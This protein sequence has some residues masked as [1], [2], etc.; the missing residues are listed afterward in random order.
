MAEETEKP[1]RPCCFSG[2]A[3]SRDSNSAVRPWSLPAPWI[4]NPLLGLQSQISDIL[5]LVVARSLKQPLTL[6]SRSQTRNREHRG[7]GDNCEHSSHRAWVLLRPSVCP[8]KWLVLVGLGWGLPLHSWSP[9]MGLPAL[10][11]SGIKGRQ[12]SRL[13]TKRRKCM[14]NGHKTVISKSSAF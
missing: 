4:P 9:W 5:S 11:E 10:Q 8:G 14:W 7:V 12:S 1:R 2:T 3:R 6:S 13:A